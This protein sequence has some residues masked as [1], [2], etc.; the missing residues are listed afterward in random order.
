M[1]PLFTNQRQDPLWAKRWQLLSGNI[2]FIKEANL[3]CLWGMPGCAVNLQVAFGFQEASLCKSTNLKW[4]I[5]PDFHVGN[6]REVNQSLV[7]SLLSAYFLNFIWVN[8]PPA[9]EHQQFLKKATISSWKSSLWT[10]LLNTIHSI[11]LMLLFMI[12][13]AVYHVYGMRKA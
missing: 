11:V 6:I 7:F 9:V 13:M 5:L 12:S 8:Y 1:L 3:Q 2:C 4:K 10:Q